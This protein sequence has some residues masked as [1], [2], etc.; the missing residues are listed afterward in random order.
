MSCGCHTARRTQWWPVCQHEDLVVHSTAMKALRCCS[1]VRCHGNKVGFVIRKHINV[2]VN[3]ASAVL[4]ASCFP[5][6]GLVTTD[7]GAARERIHWAE[8]HRRRVP[9]GSERLQLRCFLLLMEWRVTSAEV[10]GG[11]GA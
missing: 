9:G 1:S 7:R 3:M 5:R 2:D 6:P 11:Q 4:L 8:G 10:E